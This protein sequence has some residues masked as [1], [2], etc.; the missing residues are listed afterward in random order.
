V[1][2]S[3]GGANKASVPS[4]GVLQNIRKDEKEIYQ[5]LIPKQEV[6]GRT[7]LLLSFHKIW[8]A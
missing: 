8:I 2:A 3:P 4:L 6:P 7:N 5:I 1:W